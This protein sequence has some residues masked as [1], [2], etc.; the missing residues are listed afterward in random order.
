LGDKRRRALEVELRQFGSHRFVKDF[1]SLYWD[2]FALETMKGL[3]Q[4]S[5]GASKGHSS[6]S[7]APSIVAVQVHD[8][9]EGVQGETQSEPPEDT[10][11]RTRT[12][13]GGDVPCPPDLELTPDQAAQ[14]TMGL[15]MPQD[16]IARWTPVLRSKFLQSEPRTLDRWR[17]SLSTA[18]ASDWSTKRLQMLDRQQ[19]PRRGGGPIQPNGGKSEEEFLAE[20]GFAQGGA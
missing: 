1:V 2:A 7:D 13:T 9:L 8:Q 17:K 6:S 16:V 4:L 10:R 18:L 11:V 19:A 5:E 20:L 3:P 14:L 12:P 15:G